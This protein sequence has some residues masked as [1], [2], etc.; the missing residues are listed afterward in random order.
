MFRVLESLRRGFPRILVLALIGVFFLTSSTLVPLLLGP[1][2]APLAYG[3]GLTFV[4]LAVGDT[5]LRILQ[6]EVDGQLASK[7]AL[8]ESSTAAGLVYIGRSLLAVAILMLIVTAARAAEPPA[9]AV[10]VLPLLKAEQMAWWPDHPLPSALGGQVEQETC[11]SLTHWM[12]WNPK[13][14]LKTSREQGVGLGQITRTW[15]AD[16]STRFDSLAEMKSQNPRALQAWSWNDQS[17]YDPKLQLRALLLMD[18]RN[19]KALT[20]VPDKNER[21][22]MAL[23]AYNGGLGGLNQDRVACAGTKGCNRTKWWGHVEHTSLKQKT[24]VSGYGKSFY[25]INREYPRNILFVR[26]VR[27][28]SLDA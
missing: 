25:T 27:Y 7:K 15:R 13:A 4:G 9:A 14:Q 5:A 16:G 24:T 11:R 1:T 20:D 28:T 23:V 6:P 18:L 3:F 19:W 26:R 21:L 2:L 22:A 8:G 10:P 17:L 12:C